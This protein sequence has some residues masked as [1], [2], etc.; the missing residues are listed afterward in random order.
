MIFHLLVPWR[1]VCL[2]SGISAEEV[3][4]VLERELMRP[5]ILRLERGRVTRFAALAPA[6]RFH[7]LWG[8]G[9]SAPSLYVSGSA[10][11]R[12]GGSQIRF[13]MR[14]PLGASVALGA[15]LLLMPLLL[16]IFL[17][18]GHGPLDRR[19]LAPC[20]LLPLGWT[21]FSLEHQR[22]ME[23]VEELLGSIVR[24]TAL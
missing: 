20:V 19:L 15:G 8:S 18:A 6:F 13:V 22:G 14:A 7:V 23:R 3:A 4:P 21:W 16:S 5:G 17:Y 9:R 11:P 24:R 2:E 10:E 12:P 1:R